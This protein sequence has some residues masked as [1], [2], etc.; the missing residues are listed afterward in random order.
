MFSPSP[1]TS[2]CSQT[3]VTS[4]SSSVRTHPGSWWSRRCSSST[5]RWESHG[6]G[7]NSTSACRRAVV[8]GRAVADSMSTII[9]Q[10]TCGR[11]EPGSSDSIDRGRSASVA[12]SAKVEPRAS[13]PNGWPA[14]RASRIS[15]RSGSSSGAG[16]PRCDDG[17]GS[18]QLRGRVCFGVTRPP[19]RFLGRDMP[20]G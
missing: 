18:S 1:S 12:S 11:S 9:S 17:P 7:A 5:R 8:S 14:D 10:V 2:T 20:G 6:G 15:A 13:S 16:P 19:R 4:T 3:W